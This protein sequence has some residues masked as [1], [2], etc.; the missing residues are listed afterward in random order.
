MIFCWLNE[1]NGIT[2]KKISNFKFKEGDI[3]QKKNIENFK[4]NKRKKQKIILK[5]L[6]LLL[7]IFSFSS[8]QQEQQRLYVLLDVF[9]A[10]I[11]SQRF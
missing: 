6:L 2:K 9:G 5:N 8:F 4:E 10:S 3:K 7:F 11:S 1:Q